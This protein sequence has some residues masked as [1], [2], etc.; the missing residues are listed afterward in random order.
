MLS[1][2]GLVDMYDVMY[3]WQMQQPPVHR[4]PYQLAPVPA[5]APLPHPSSQLPAAI[6]GSQKYSDSLP[7]A[8]FGVVP[9]PHPVQ[10]AVRASALPAPNFAPQLPYV[11]P[12]S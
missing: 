1:E 3:R 8:S 7:W 11:Q 9:Q 12:T 5:S 6:Y 10:P 4:Q 2:D